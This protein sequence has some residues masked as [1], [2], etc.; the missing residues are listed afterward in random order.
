MGRGARMR[1][2]LGAACAAAAVALSVPAA[3]QTPAATPTPAEAA[4]PAS[5]PSPDAERPA[6]PPPAK[7]SKTLARPD[8]RY[9]HWL[10]SAGGGLWVP[11]GNLI[12][13]GPGLAA[14]RPGGDAP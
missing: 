5:G 1:I 7:R 2:G 4:A 12:P 8:L 13:T 6:E 10:I 14:L 11:S 9:G 3:A